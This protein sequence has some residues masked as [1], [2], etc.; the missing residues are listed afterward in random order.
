MD[1]CVDGMC[2]SLSDIPS[3]IHTDFMFEQGFPFCNLHKHSLHTN[4]VQLTYIFS[5]LWL[6]WYAF[7]LL[8]CMEFVPWA[9]S[10]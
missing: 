7:G 1:I 3:D 9:Y 4:T 5:V 6:N 8:K 10:S 2:V